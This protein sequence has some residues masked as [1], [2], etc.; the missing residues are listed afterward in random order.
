MTA[1]RIGTRGS[2]LALAQ[3]RSVAA[4]LAALQPGLEPE[5]VPIATRGDR[6]TE[7]PSAGLGGKGIFVREI[8]DALLAGEIRLA[9]HS[10]KDLPAMLPPG[11]ALAGFPRRADPRDLL[12]TRE[13][14]P[15]DELPPGARVATG[16]PRRRAQL[17]ARR[18]DLRFADLRGNVDTRVRKL[19][20]G[21]ADAIVLAAA[22]IERLGLAGRVR[23]EPLDE[24]LCVPAP[25]QGIIGVEAREND[26]E[27]CALAV[28]VSDPRSVVEACAERAF[29][30]ALGGSCQ[31]PAAALAR[32]DGQRVRMRARI[33]S[34]DG[35]R[36]AEATG[37][38]RCEDGWQVGDSVAR[39]CLAHGGDEI[40][41]GLRGDH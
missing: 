11:L 7:A 5:I 16:S 39:A 27:A 18:P 23:G 13:G 9:V 34:R 40:L 3:A 24:D 14:T 22:G 30:T 15:F 10:V 32:C 21:V 37:E 26:G 28:R 29:L 12:I 41:A 31:L 35:G 19:E 17:A 33:L 20:E 25:G 36:V 8:E 38:G 6:D 1:F 2:P 4:A